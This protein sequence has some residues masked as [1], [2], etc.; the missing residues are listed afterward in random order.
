MINMQELLLAYLLDP[1]DQPFMQKN[2]V[3]LVSDFITNHL[4]THCLNQR[5]FIT[6]INSSVGLKLLLPSYYTVG[7]ACRRAHLC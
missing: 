1:Q 7:A 5:I 2:C 6:S 3:Y 4:K